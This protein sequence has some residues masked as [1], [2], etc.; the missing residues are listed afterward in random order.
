MRAL[1]HLLHR[2]R[3]WL[4][5]QGLR[6]RV[7]Q[8]EAELRSTEDDITNDTAWLASLRS[9]LATTRHRL[10]AAQLAP[11][12]RNRGATHPRTGD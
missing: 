11:R 5:V 12:A 8:L 6:A 2:V 4:A 7:R 1:P 3:R 9:E 10:E